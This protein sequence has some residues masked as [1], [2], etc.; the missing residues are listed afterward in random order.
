MIHDV[1]L[2]NETKLYLDQ[3]VQAQ[4]DLLIGAAN[5]QGAFA[6]DQLRLQLATKMSG[7]RADQLASWLFHRKVPAEAV[8]AFAAYNDVATKTALAEQMRRDVDRLSQGNIQ[9]ELE[10]Q[11]TRMN[12]L[13]GYLKG[14]Y[15]FLVYF[16][17]YL[18]A[19][20]SM[21]LFQEN[22]FNFYKYGRK[23]FLAA[24]ERENPEQY[25]CAICDEHRYMT[26][27]RGK[28]SS[29]IEHYFPKA[30]YPHLSVHPYNLIPICGPCNTVHLDKDPLSK[31]DG[32][33]RTLGEIYL[34]YRAESVAVQ[35][36]IRLTWQSTDPPE[37]RP[38]LQIQ[39]RQVNDGTLQA[40]LQA[41]S[42]IYDIPGRWQN[43]IHQIGEQLWRYIRHYV[44]VEIDGEVEIDL[45]Q[46]KVE[47]ERL[48]G[49]LFEDLGK[50]PWTY[51]LIWYLSNILIEEIE[52][53]IPNS[54][55]SGVTPAAETIREMLKE[56]GNLIA[57]H[58]QA[59]REA[60]ALAR[61]MYNPR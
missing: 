60:L 10:Y 61:D 25:V 1:K 59:A 7:Q 5:L 41:F 30:I 40:K 49:Y 24:Y 31:Q 57:P 16:Y 58:V 32:N 11:A 8:G 2:P 9:E 36:A 19:G 23:Q 56:R 37:K 48:L 39:P 17:E 20:L 43:R 53:A 44:R 29:D 54:G 50:G 51:G 14:A 15:D 47:L 34:P 26:V 27:F 12:P 28:Y 45:E 42:E 55:G 21:E 3:V 22:P 46:L 52:A 18:D 13:P 33:R 35:G 4:M 38:S 6:Q